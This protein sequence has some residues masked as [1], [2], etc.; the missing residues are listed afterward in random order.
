M[1]FFDYPN[2][3][4]VDQARWEEWLHGTYNCPKAVVSTTLIPPAPVIA[5]IFSSHFT[6]PSLS[7]STRSFYTSLW[8]RRDSSR[9]LVQRSSGEPHPLPLSTTMHYHY[10]SPPSPPV[11]PSWLFLYYSLCF[12]LWPLAPTWV[13]GRQHGTTSNHERPMA[14][15]CGTGPVLGTHFTKVAVT[16]EEEEGVSPTHHVYVTHRHQHFPMLHIREAR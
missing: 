12:S 3:S 15:L 9:G 13:S 11:P 10:P 16:E 2:L 8:L 6:T 14:P 4:S 7:P 1:A 5:G